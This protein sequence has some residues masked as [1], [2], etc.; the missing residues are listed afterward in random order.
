M[1]YE[2]CE[3]GA[4]QVCLWYISIQPTNFLI[5]VEGAYLELAKVGVFCWGQGALI[6]LPIRIFVVLMKFLEGHVCDEGLFRKA[7]SV[8]RQRKLRVSADPQQSGWV[9][10]G[11]AQPSWGLA[12]MYRVAALT[13]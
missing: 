12:G 5:S 9:G 3:G 4:F 1:V 6:L 13:S 11:A 10:G 7:G 8:S 2:V